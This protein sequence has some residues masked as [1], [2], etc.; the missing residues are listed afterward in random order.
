LA[1]N[2]LIFLKHETY[3][4]KIYIILVLQKFLFFFF[5]CSLEFIAVVIMV[6]A[7]PSVKEPAK[8]KA[9]SDKKVSKTLH[10]ERRITRAKVKARSG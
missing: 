5:F 3:K 8:R 6:M 4:K 2:G 10:V 7:M 1:V 9:T